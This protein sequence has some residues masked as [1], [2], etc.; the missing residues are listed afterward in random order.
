MPL[1]QWLQ[2]LLD[3]LCKIYRYWF[4]K[5]CSDFE[6]DPS[7]AIV[8]VESTYAKEGPPVFT[9]SG[10]KEEFLNWLTALEA[11]LAMPGNSLTTAQNASLLAFIASLRKQ[12]G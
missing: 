9:Q 7:L 10:Q 8:L 2:D 5:E 11:L 1:S 6:G 12:L 3:I 4:G